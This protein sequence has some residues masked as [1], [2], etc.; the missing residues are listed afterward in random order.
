[1][2]G[3]IEGMNDVV[4]GAGVFGLLAVN[5]EGD[6]AGLD[7]AFDG[8]QRE[9]IERSGFEVFGLSVVDLGKGLRVSDFAVAL[10]AFAEEKFD[11]I[12]PGAFL[13]G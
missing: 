10:L 1:M 8:D 9:G 11:G 13:R 7:L 6:G 12:E 3:I 4:S 5:F 2:D